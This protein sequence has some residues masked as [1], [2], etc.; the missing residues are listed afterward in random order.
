MKATIVHINSKKTH[1]IVAV[2]KPIGPVV[3]RISGNMDLANTDAKVGDTFE[4]EDAQVVS[5][6]VEDKLN[7]GQMITFDRLVLR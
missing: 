6:T 4:C 1:C 3:S 7:P 5:N 2:H